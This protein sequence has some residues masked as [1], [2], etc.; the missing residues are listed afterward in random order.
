MLFSKAPAGRGPR[1]ARRGETSPSAGGAVGRAE[2]LVGGVGLA[3][4][5]GQLLVGLLEVLQGSGTIPEC[6][7]PAEVEQD[8]AALTR[9]ARL[10]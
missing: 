7:G 6:L 10:A 5:F 1:V 2:Q 4:R 9:G 3:P 8:V